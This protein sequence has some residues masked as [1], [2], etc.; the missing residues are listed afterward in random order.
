MAMI[1]SNQ[2]GYDIINNTNFDLSKE[3]HYSIP[4]PHKYAN[5]VNEKGMMSLML[6][7][8]KYFNTEKYYPGFKLLFSQN[9]KSLVPLALN[10]I[11]NN[12]KEL[13]FFTKYYN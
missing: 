6:Y 2:T 4:Y 11:P 10:L 8:I 13:C 5:M 7:L 9:L 12:L 3:I 1:N